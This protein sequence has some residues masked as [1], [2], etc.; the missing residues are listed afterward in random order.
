MAAENHLPPIEGEPREDGRWT[1]VDGRWHE[2]VERK[3]ER[4]P[5]PDE[6]WERM[7][8]LMIATREDAEEHF[9]EIDFDDYPEFEW[10]E[11]EDS[12]V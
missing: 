3:D 8:G 12:D 5:S 9:P 10:D 11:E 6:L 2:V 1:F 4:D 7:A